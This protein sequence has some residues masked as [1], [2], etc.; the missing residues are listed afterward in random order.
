MLPAPSAAE[1]SASTAMRAPALS[2]G[3]L[4]VIALV[5]VA[6]FAFSWLFRFNNPGGS[7]AGLTDDD[8]FYLVR[9]WQILF[10]DLPVRDFVDHGAPLYYYLAAAVQVLGGR[11]TLS[12]IVF[13]IT[14]LSA[15]ATAVF[16]LG[17]RASGSILIGLAVAVVHVLLEPRLYNYPKILVYVAAIPALWA[18]ADRPGA[19]RRALIAA[20]TVAG[21]LFRH[22]HGA[23]VAAAFAVLL[24]LL[25]TLT[26]RER[27]RHAVAYALLVLLLLAPYLVFIEMNGGVVSYFRQA[28]AWAERDRARAEVVWPGLFDNPDGVSADAKDGSGVIRALGTLHDNSVAWLFYAELALPIVALLV[29][30]VSRDGFR[31]DW[32]QARVKI[33][34]VA[35][36]ALILD[37][38][39]LRSPLGA[40]LADPSVAHAILLAWL[41]VALAALVTGRATFQPW[42]PAAVAAR[43]V[44]AV[45]IASLLFVAMVTSARDWEQRLDRASLLDGPGRTMR[46]MHHVAASIE[47][48]WELP[49]GS[50]PSG[51]M[52][53]TRYLAD[54]TKPTDRVFMQQYLPEVIALSRR[55][56]AGGH[57]DLRPGFFTSDD[58]QQLTVHRLQ[59]QTVPVV[60]LATGAD[61]DHFRESFPQVT[62]YFDRQ[63]TAAGDRQLD[64]RYRVHLLVA[65]T[66]T[67]HGRY[68]PL[69][70]PCFR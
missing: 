36:L 67:A 19:W 35:V 25:P 22:D 51:L 6:L 33:A 62:A 45:C 61:L 65:N 2:T 53:L 5:G 15:C 48:D 26:W 68:E 54:C 56:F 47:Q 14:V 24:V 10:G 34:T 39:F 66:A 42:V 57:A 30:A 64:E 46:T 21:F 7:F 32:P 52:K 9:G 8:F 31:P 4:V 11:G 17:I 55:G 44:I 43:G 27:V 63:Y 49:G 3:R 1:R 40:R 58:M 59:H 13:S 18:F 28:S 38:G 69:D 29:V 12:E 41:A 70:W 37:A 16:L 23:F 20:I 50:H 60:L